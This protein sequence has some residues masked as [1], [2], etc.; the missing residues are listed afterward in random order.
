MPAFLLKG[1]A[2]TKQLKIDNGI[3]MRTL[4]KKDKK[5][6]LIKLFFN[7]NSVS[8]CVFT[9]LLLTKMITQS[10]LC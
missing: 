4:S 3:K 7:I 2:R 9:E 8:K 1:F 5:E 10:N 6:S